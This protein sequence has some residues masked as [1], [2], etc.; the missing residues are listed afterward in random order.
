MHD[1]RCLVAGGLATGGLADVCACAVFLG[2]L[3]VR[4]CCRAWLKAV[5]PCGD[6][7]AEVVGGGPRPASGLLER[8]GTG[9]WRWR[10][11]DRWTSVV[12]C[13]PA[14]YLCGCA[15]CWWWCRGGVVWWSGVVAWSLVGGGCW[16]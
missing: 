9:E 14:A 4:P 11:V 13:L 16:C 8:S 3:A 15:W 10:A 2:G 1:G 12:R 7:R 6:P 5:R